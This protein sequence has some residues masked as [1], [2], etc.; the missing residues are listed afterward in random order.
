MLIHIERS[1]TCSI[2]NTHFVNTNFVLSRKKMLQ[3]KFSVNTLE[4]ININPPST[5]YSNEYLR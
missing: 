5:Y 3:N 4:L 1:S 2:I